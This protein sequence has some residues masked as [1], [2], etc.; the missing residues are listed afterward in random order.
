MKKEA[1]QQKIF[2]N[3]KDIANGKAGIAST[4]INMETQNAQDQGKIAQ[5]L[6]NATAGGLMYGD[7]SRRNPGP[8]KDDPTPDY[9]FGSGSQQYP[10][11]QEDPEVLKRARAG[12][13]SPLWNGWG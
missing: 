13:K 7:P 4:A 11:S 6:G 8:A 10:S 9:D 12:E 2:D 1:I 3:Q 5:G